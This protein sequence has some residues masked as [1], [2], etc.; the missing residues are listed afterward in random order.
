[1]IGLMKSKKYRR[2]T[3]IASNS[4]RLEIRQDFK[5]KNP[6]IRWSDI[7]KLKLAYH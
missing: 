1:M 6:T 5:S 3:L 2:D 4:M 7:I